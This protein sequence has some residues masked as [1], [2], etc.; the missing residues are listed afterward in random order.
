LSLTDT[1]IDDR[2]GVALDVRNLG[3]APIRIYA[4][5]NS[6][7]WERGYVAVAPG[8]TGTLYILARRRTLAPALARE[9]PQM[10]G[11]PGGKMSLWAGIDEP[12]HAREL[13]VFA[14]APAQPLKVE[15]GNVRAF[16]SSA[17]PSLSGFFPFVDRYG[18]YQHKEWPGKIHADADLAGHRTREDADLAAH[19]GPPDLDQ[20][21]GWASGPPLRATG[22]FR[23]EK[24]AGQWW[25]VDPAGRLFWSNGLDGVNFFQS[26]TPISG[27][28]RF[29]ADPAPDGSFLTR[30]LQI[31][32]GPGWR[33]AVGDRLLQ[34]IRSWGLNTLGGGGDRA[35]MLKHRVPYT[36]QIWTSRRS[37]A[38]I[39]PDSPAWNA[40]LRQVL[41]TAAA[42]VKDDPWCIGFFVDN[43]IHVS[44]EPAWFDAYYRQVSAVAR[45]LLPDTLYLG[46]R[47]DFHDWPAVTTER[48]EIVRLAAKYCDV[49]SFNLYTYTLEDFVLPV[50][51]DRPA[52]VGEFHMGALDRG[53][54]HTG[55]R[56]VIDQDHRAEAYRYYVG[57]ALR[58]PLIVGAHWFQ[59]YDEALTGRFDGENYQIGFLD[60]GDSPYAETVAAARDIGYRLYAI[61]ADAA[62][63][64]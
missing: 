24:V 33:E 55:L 32:Y 19:P 11:V 53:L 58:N 4:D 46:S 15:V 64:R 57:T 2:L 13:R 30:N 36:L 31:K 9:F 26:L 56:G 38:P 61:R 18:Q 44:A 60:V 34:R 49:V 3:S 6:N 23:V 37:E 47:L 39:D 59:C 20:Y 41:A 52:L 62:G 35:L 22:H 17:V 21:G 12:I 5:L 45:A 29:Y 27:R 42:A 1:D 14:V 48:K 8:E 54:F 7:T 10:H 25:F 43:E 51:V 16:G 63:P 28:E 40:R 50:G